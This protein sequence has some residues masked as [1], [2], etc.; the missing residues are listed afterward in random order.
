MGAGSDGRRLR[1]GS[2]LAPLAGYCSHYAHRPDFVEAANLLAARSEL[3][4]TLITTGS[5][6]TTPWMHSARSAP[7]LSFGAVNLLGMRR[8]SPVYPLIPYRGWHGEPRAMANKHGRRPPAG[9]G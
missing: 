6:P 4:S 2:P 1:K 7:N 3:T 8:Q 9:R 5:Q